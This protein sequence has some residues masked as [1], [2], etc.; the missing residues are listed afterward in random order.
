MILDQIANLLLYPAGIPDAGRI[1]AAYQLGGMVN[2]APGGISKWVV[3]APCGE[4][5]A[6][7]GGW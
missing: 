2:S 3:K 1:A 5:F 6:V 7:T 4:R